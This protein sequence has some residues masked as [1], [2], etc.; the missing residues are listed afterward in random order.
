M[1]RKPE[2]SVSIPVNQAMHT[3]KELH[4]D[5]TYTSENT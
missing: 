5:A 4:E 3:N 2:K 1:L